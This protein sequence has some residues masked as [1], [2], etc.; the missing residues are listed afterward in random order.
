MSSQ[1]AGKKRLASTRSGFHTPARP[2][3][4]SLFGDVESVKNAVLSILKGTD[5]P[6]RSTNAAQGLATTIENA[7][8]LLNIPKDNSRIPA[9]HRT[10]L[11]KFIA[12]MG[13]IQRKLENAS[14]ERGKEKRSR[15]NKIAQVLTSQ[16]RDKCTKIL[17]AC[18]KHV[19]AALASLP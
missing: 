12:E 4:D 1:S 6:R 2:L 18:A 17:E 8:N 7:S 13:G 14:E 3:H 9:Q 16:E 11:E 19:E 5:W 15:L 10:S